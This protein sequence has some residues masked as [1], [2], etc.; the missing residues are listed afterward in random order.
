M[1]MGA[2]QTDCLHSKRRFCRFV[3]YCPFMHVYLGLGQCAGG[4]GVYCAGQVIPNI[5]AEHLRCS[6]NSNVE[7]VEKILKM[8]FRQF[9]T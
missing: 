1:S 6:L 5:Q 9:S 7:P 4:F 3:Y 2:K 8:V